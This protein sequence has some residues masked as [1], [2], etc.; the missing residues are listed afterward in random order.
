MR[1]LEAALRAGAP[2]AGA[3]HGP[4]DVHG[5]ARRP[6]LTAS[7]ASTGCIGNR[8]YTDLGDDELYVAIPGK[9][10]AKLA[11]EIADHRRGQRRAGRLPSRAAPGPLH[12]VAGASGMRIGVDLGGTKIEAIALDRDGRERGRRRVPTPARP[13]RR[14][15]GR[16][17]HAG[18][19]ARARGRRAGAGR[20]RH[21]GRALAGHRARQER[22][23]RL[24]Q[25]PP[26][27]PGPRAPP[28]PAPPLRER[29]ELLRAVG[30]AATAPARGRAS[31]SASSWAP[32]T[33]GG[34]VVDGRVLTGP[35]AIAGEWGHNPLPW[36]R[37]GEWPGAACYCGRTGCIETFLSGPGNRPRSPRGH[38]RGARR[39][40]DRRARGRRRRALRGDA[41]AL[42]GAARAGAGVGRQPARPRR[43]R[44]RAAASRTSPGS[45]SGFRSAGARG[46]SRTA[47]TPPLRPPQHGDSSG[48]R[49]AAWLWEAAEDDGRPA[50]WPPPAA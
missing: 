7:L 32:G 39:D 38:G 28:P 31:S 22:Q 23:Q 18:R 42:R 34:I 19:G 48:V 47:S 27:S 41:R 21:A 24:A 16:D 11:A 50:P 26:A 37:A 35:N 13:L 10:L 25:R 49:G 4:P 30:G 15:A 44:A 8:V 43:D 29:R 36:P 5:A 9:D 33:G 40:D 1:L 6:R 2:G 12:G 20:H 46:C 45:T 17:H 3:V 14:D